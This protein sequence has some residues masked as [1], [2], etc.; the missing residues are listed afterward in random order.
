MWHTPRSSFAAI[1]ARLGWLDSIGWMQ[2]RSGAMQAWVERI[3]RRGEY[4]RVVVL[5]MGGASMAAAVF[6]A[7]FKPARGYLPLT[8]VDTTHPDEIARL[9]GGSGGGDWDLRRCLFV[10]A[11]KSGATLETMAL[12]RYFRA[13]LSAQGAPPQA[14][15]VLITDADSALHRLSQTE[16]FRETFINPSD[17][18]GRYS[19]LSY[20]GM[21]PAALL[22]VAVD[23]VLQR[24]Q[25]FCATTKSDQPA[26]NPALAL[27]MLLARGAGAGKAQLILRLP[28]QLCALGRWI[29]QL[30]AESCGK[31]G[32]GLLPVVAVHGMHDGMDFC[33]DRQRQ[34]I[35]RLGDAPHRPPSAASSPPPSPHNEQTACALPFTDAH[36]IGAE[37]FRWQMAVAIAASELRINPFDQPHVEQGK[38]NTQLFLQGR[39]RLGAPGWCGAQYDLYGCNATRG[40][41]ESETEAGALIA[42]FRRTLTPKHYLALLAYLPEDAQTIALLHSLRA[43]VSAQLRMVCTLGFGP[44]YL[45]STGQLHKGG[46]PSGRFIQLVAAADED[47]AL[48]QCEYSFGQLHRAQADGDFLALRRAERVIMRVRLKADRIRSLTRFVSDFIGAAD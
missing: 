17:I 28:Q 13:R 39:E 30:V 33:A 36:Q 23:E 43:Q 42:A 21:L 31:D 48:P 27:G 4:E 37:F 41:P 44:R 3:V 32:K 1:A 29:E 20:F 24:A 35:I 25:V 16:P 6:A 18:G 12:Y 7:L 11:S 40:D 34:I 19:A 22:G 10:V 26:Q 8:V 47:I 45:H 9:G 38:R 5:G 15:F 2:A 46:P 14:N